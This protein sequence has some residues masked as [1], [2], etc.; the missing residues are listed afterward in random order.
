MKQMKCGMLKSPSSEKKDITIVVHDLI[1]GC[2]PTLG[3]SIKSK[4]GH[5]STLLNASQTTNFTFKVQGKKMDEIEIFEF[6]AI[7]FNK[8]KIQSKIMFLKKEGFDFN[9]I[10]LDNEIF[11]SNLQMSDTFLPDIISVLLLNYY[12]GFGPSIEELTKILEKINPCKYNLEDGHNFYK[13]KIK[14]F[15]TNIALGMLPSK[16]WSGKFDATGGYIVVK[17]DGEVLCYHIYNL[18]EFQEYLFMNTKLETPS[19]TR[20]DFGYLYNYDDDLLI[21]LNLQIRFK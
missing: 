8:S 14:L 2:T 18:N 21:K 1:T 15:L 19:T 17:E 7:K 13:Y 20:H 10:G 3:F 12:L 5:P 4:L 11:N 16:T 6:N 9:F